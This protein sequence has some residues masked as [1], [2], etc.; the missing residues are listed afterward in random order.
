[1]ST[2]VFNVLFVCTGNTARSVLAESILQKLGQGR[3]QAYSAGSQPKGQVNPLALNTLAA[4]DF[5]EAGLRSK[6]WDEFA[7]SGAPA[8]DFIFTVCDSAEGEACPFWPG[9]PF[10][11]HWGIADP[12]AAVGTE[13]DKQR[14]FNEAFRLLK[15]R[16]AAFVALPFASLDTLATERKLKEIGAMPGASAGAR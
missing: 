13:M 6:S 14:A 10:S 2:R 4:N 1:M 8:M 16:I 5:P 3:F 11:A 9:K 12:A 7:A 15:N